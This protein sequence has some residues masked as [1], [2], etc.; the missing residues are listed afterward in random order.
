MALN[1]NFFVCKNGILYSLTL[2]VF[3]KNN[4]NR[5]NV[6]GVDRCRSIYNF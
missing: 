2:L 3:T 4:R 5:Y 1:G 6:K